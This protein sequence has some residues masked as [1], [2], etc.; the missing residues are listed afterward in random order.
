MAVEVRVLS[1][2]FLSANLCVSVDFA[3]SAF[4]VAVLTVRATDTSG[5]WVESELAGT[6]NDPPVINTFS[7]E[8]QPQGFWLFEGTL[9]DESRGS[10]VVRFTGLFEDEVTANPDGTFSI[11][12]QLGEGVWGD[13]FAQATDEFGLQSN[14]AVTLVGIT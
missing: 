10:V 11:S 14:I 2:A 9:A 12:K 1:L 4:G 5:L 7:H 3:T 6:L 8:A 13:V